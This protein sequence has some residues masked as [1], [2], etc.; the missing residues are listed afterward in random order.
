MRG[1][2]TLR[3]F[4]LV[5][6]LCIGTFGLMSTSVFAE[7]DTNPPVDD[8]KQKIADVARD[9]GIPP[10]IL[11][12]IAANESA[13]KQFDEDGSPHISPDGGIGIMQVT[14]DSIHMDVDEEKLKTDLDYNI[15]MGAQVLLNKWE[16]DFLPTMNEH[17]KSVL[18]DWYFA[19][20]AYNGLS[21]AN[22]PNIH[23]DDAYQ[24]KIYQRIE[25]SAF[26]YGEG[27]SYFAFPEIDINYKDNND[28]MFFPADKNHYES[29]T[30]T[31]SQQMYE[32]GDVVYID[33]REGFANISEG[34]ITGAKNKLW[35]Y[36]PLTITSDDPVESSNAAN[37]FAYYEVEGVTADGYV[38]SAYLN[39]GSKELVFNDPVDDHRAAAL[40]FVSMNGYA[41][42]YPNGHFGSNDPLRREHVAVMLTN[43]LSLEAPDSYE[44][45]AADAE[46]I[47]NYREALRKAEYNGLLGGGGKLRPKETL[48]RAQMAQV[49]SNAFESYYEEPEST[50]AFKDADKIWNLEEV[51]T[52]YHNN[53]TVAD[54]FRP[55]EDITRSQFAIFIYRTMVDVVTD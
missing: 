29:R 30:V 26:I 40:A 34:A 22:D 35:P 54:P 23:P 47:D 33:D 6:V 27:E 32:Q 4:L 7:G 20:A 3:R 1:G 17:D 28:K 9:K 46:S 12:A 55:N 44:I 21:K 42:G 41:Q 49:M 51:N 50:H 2:L 19:L 37:D 24:E 38:A 53:V 8:V 48:T 10:E 31:P 52:M 5:V 15:E 13:Y 39:Q 45:Q 25:Q 11:K 36:T 16:L 18:E 14:P 43:I